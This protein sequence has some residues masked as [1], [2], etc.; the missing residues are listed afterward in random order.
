VGTDIHLAEK[1][2]SLLKKGDIVT[3]GSR[4][5]FASEELYNMM[6]QVNEEL[7]KTRA[8]ALSN[9]SAANS[10]VHR[11]LAEMLGGALAVPY[12]VNESVVMGQ[13]MATGEVLPLWRIGVEVGRSGSFAVYYRRDEASSSQSALA[14]AGSQSALE[15]IRRKR[16][17]G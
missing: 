12:S 16:N 6:K 3:I 5:S 2:Y 7:D 11:V 15:V 1:L 10:R 13:N 8:L 9:T 17:G 14:S 4:K